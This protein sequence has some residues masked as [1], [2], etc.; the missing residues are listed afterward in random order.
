M[1]AE[2]QKLIADNTQLKTQADQLTEQLSGKGDLEAQHAKA[3][4]DHTTTS[5]QQIAALTDENNRK[6]QD[7]TSQINAKDAEIKQVTDEL[8]KA[9]EEAASHSTTVTESQR[10]AATEINALKAQIQ[11]LTEQNTDLQ[12]RIT[13]ATS[14]INDATQNLAQL[15]DDSINQA[16]LQGINDAFSELEKS[17]QAISIAIDAAP[18]V[19]PEAPPANP[20]T[21]LAAPPANVLPPDTL[22]TIS[23][24]GVKA[25]L[26]LSIIITNLKK[27]NAQVGRDPNNKYA[28]ALAK[29]Q[30]AKN[31]QDVNNAL[32]GLTFKN[33]AFM[34]GKTKK[35][36]KNRKNKNT[37]KQKGGF[38]YSSNSRRRSLSSSRKTTTSK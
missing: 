6:I 33:G 16:N 18:P 21:P 30:N 12:N 14:A 11:T 4:Q 37:K 25:T 17:I 19:S 8:K 26:P 13:A 15:T 28:V 2:I 5:Q 22:I 27:K 1:E 23:S 36:K 7:L 20:G 24:N 29:I 35:T 3:I 32:F 9:Q 38:R 34:G 10:Q 31:V